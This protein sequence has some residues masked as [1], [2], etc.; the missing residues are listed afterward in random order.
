MRYALILISLFALTGCPA[1]VVTGG[2]VAATTVAQ[3]RT[4]GNAVDDTGLYLAIKTKFLESDVNNLLAKVGVEVIE[5][6][7]LL[8]GQVPKPE[9]AIQAITLTWQVDGVREVI[10]ELQVQD[11]SSLTDYAKD[12]WITTQVKSKLLIT[13][14]IRSINYSI[15]TVNAEVY[16]MGIAQS[17]TELQQV[18]QISRTISGVKRVISHVR[19][20]DDPRRN[21]PPQ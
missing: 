17:D 18:V 12:V 14:N 13:K 1:A 6:R 16:L 2:G 10:N 11:K 21:T 3:E 5:G 4:V 9:D 19:L 20:K 7:V 8:T 15:E